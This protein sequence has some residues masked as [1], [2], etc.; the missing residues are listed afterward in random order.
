[1]D[2]LDNCIKI[3]DAGDGTQ[4]VENVPNFQVEVNGTR[5]ECYDHNLPQNLSNL[6]YQV[7]GIFT[8]GMIILFGAM[9]LRYANK[10]N[11][12]GTESDTTLAPA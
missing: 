12:G 9:M 8:F 11:S 1:M 10:Q 7:P 3:S 6:R 4:K 2:T 5:Y